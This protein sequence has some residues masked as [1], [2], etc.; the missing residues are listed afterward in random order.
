MHNPP[1]EQRRPAH[2]GTRRWLRRLAWAGLILIALMAALLL[3]VRS[4]VLPDLEHF[5][6]ALESQLSQQ[7]GVQ[8]RIEKLSGH[9]E[10]FSPAIALDKLQLEDGGLLTIDG[11][12]AIVDWRGLLRGRLR[13]EELQVE[14]AAVS[15]EH[16]GFRRWR[17]AGQILDL[18][19]PLS[20]VDEAQPWRLPDWLTVQGNLR[21]ADLSVRYRDRV[22]DERVAIE[23]VRIDAQGRERSRRV[24]IIV[25]PVPGLSGPAAIKASLRRRGDP[26]PMHDANWDGQI[27][28]EAGA[29]DLERLTRLTGGPI[30]AGD[31][32]VDLRGWADILSNRFSSARL[33]VAGHDLQLRANEAEVL[34]PTADLD[35]DISPRPSGGIEIAAR[36]AWATDRAG[37]RIEIGSGPQR[38][39]VDRSGRPV[40]GQF[41][42]KRFDA[43]R[44]LAFARELPF[45]AD[46]RAVME[47]LRASGQVDGLTLWF[48]ASVGRTRYQ[49]QAAFSGLT[50][51]Y[52]SPE[53][54]A[55]ALNRWDPRLPAFENVS[56]SISLT[57]RDGAL[58]I[59]ADDAVV[60]FPGVF[61]EPRIALSRLDAQVVWRVREG[62]VEVA[63][64][65]P[66]VDVELQ[67]IGFA[68]AHGKGSAHGHYRTADAGPGEIDL[69]AEMADIDV[70]QVHRYLPLTMIPK[71]RAWFRQGLRAGRAK[72]ASLE[73]R[74]NLTDFPFR[75]QGSGEFD[76]VFDVEKGRLRYGPD[77]PELEGFEGR[78]RIRRGG[79]ASTV[80]RGSVSGMPV[81]S[82]SARITDFRTPVLA[83][84]GR[85][86]GQGAGL[87]R[88]L[89][90]SPL[91]FKL[92]A[93]TRSARIDGAVKTELSLQLPLEDFDAFK[94]SGVT[95][96]SGA[97]VQVAPD[98][99]RFE[100][101]DGEVRFSELGLSFEDLSASLY[102]GPVT[103][104]ASS[105]RRGQFELRLAGTAT[106]AGLRAAFDN[107][108]M[109]RLEG[110]TRYRAEL[111]WRDGR[112]RLGV[113]SN[114]AGLKSGLPPPFRKSATTPAMFEAVLEPR[115]DRSGRLLG[116]RLRVR[117]RD[118][119][120]LV[121]ERSAADDRR[122]RVQRGTVAIGAEPVLPQ[123]GL[124]VHGHL[125]VLD[126]DAW[127]RLLIDEVLPFARGQHASGGYFEGFE[128]NP[129]AVSLTADHVRFMSKS[130]SQAVLGGTRLADLWRIN[131]H[132][133]ELDGY[134]TWQSDGGAGRLM[135]RFSHLH[136]PPDTVG[137]I[138]QAIED[139]A[140]R[141]LPALDIV[142]NDFQFSGMALGRLRLLAARQPRSPSWTIQRLSLE[143][144]AARL[145]ASGRWTTPATG[146]SGTEL[147]FDIDL[148]NAGEFL[149]EL[150]FRD[151]LA[152]GSGKLLGRLGWSGSPLRL[153]K[154]SLHGKVAVS[155]QRGQF[156]KADPGIA[157]LIGVLSLQ[158][159]P[160]RLSLDF[161]DVFE[162]GFAFDAIV[163]EADI[164]DG[165]ARTDSLLMHGL[166]AQVLI[167]GEVD[168]AGE[169][170]K[171]AVDVL[172]NINAGIASIAYA[173]MANPAVGIGTLLAQMLLEN[174][175][176]R[177]FAYE[178][179]I[180]GP[181]ADPTVEQ[182]NR[183]EP[184]KPTGTEYING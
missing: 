81:Y 26:D 183:N 67:H 50:A 108:A 127:S 47:P 29:V 45:P 12:A 43:E 143:T 16:L 180:T 91:A 36:R 145:A 6:P 97:R 87:V 132:S 164:A 18:A 104:Q 170:Q 3:L 56:G 120:R 27:F 53:A 62:A 22:S 118:D 161:S 117:L 7:L 100:Q 34:L 28:I 95:R 110:R 69:H 80:A 59:A 146:R 77:W 35:L 1:L 156:L 4:W 86:G 151:T 111:S 149:T 31:G 42:L 32:F 112:V 152:G 64:G 121:L 168:I 39:I 79:M 33:A 72:H 11:M 24:A 94:L 133:E 90:G 19:G 57:D 73:L 122:W 113:H 184:E 163:G 123:S 99:P 13:F 93:L 58:D 144:S 101:V 98:L 106:A 177:L 8:V 83:I 109:R 158:S 89:N 165:V 105:P 38:L 182:T 2:S 49:M 129:S 20:H 119:V 166:Q 48:D 10:G 85:L 150:G 178:F 174:P 136:V 139:Q 15:I 126:A 5:R 137:V 82:A 175:L 160:R 30:R 153:H 46:M 71:V 44:L 138:E 78:V 116:D 21:I 172:P 74:G 131:L 141:D 60:L 169:T 37:T 140:T 114:L 55:P 173:A 167:A 159:I 54:G 142:A 128:L 148:A 155:M 96:L 181:W 125:A 75:A 63:S 134:M 102:G 107:P 41:S 65:R 176:R 68:N 171:L 40:L 115:E 9:L 25:P 103:L 162:K 14:H 70:R 51:S 17:I 61:V 52:W 84:Q 157:K 92:G 154:P 76:L 124:S 23:R 66:H 135:A 88:F 147:D 179:A 130:F